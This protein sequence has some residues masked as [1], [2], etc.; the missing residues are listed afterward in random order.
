MT[1]CFSCYDSSS[2]SKVSG[3]LHVSDPQTHDGIHVIL[4]YLHLHLLVVRT[5]F[6][7]TCQ[8]LRSHLGT[9]LH[10]FWRRKLSHSAIQLS[11]KGI[12]LRYEELQASDVAG[13]L[14]AS[15]PLLNKYALIWTIFVISVNCS[16]ILKTNFST[17]LSV[18]SVDHHTINWSVADCFA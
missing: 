7:S 14:S 6:V 17:L 9:E 16:Y 15:F 5:G 1:I 3:L 13:R 11:D 10:V 4:I 2:V 12:D 18:S 8:Q